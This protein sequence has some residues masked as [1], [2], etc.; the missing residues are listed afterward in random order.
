M[1]IICFLAI[2]FMLV[3]R[4]AAATIVVLAAFVCAGI[5][6]ALINDQPAPATR[7]A[8]MLESGVISSGDPVEVTG[9]VQGEP[10]P[11]PQSFYLTVKAERISVEGIEREASGIV[12]KL[13]IA[14][15][16]A[17]GVAGVRI[18]DRRRCRAP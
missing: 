16:V 15:A 12:F 18:V 3:R 9:V 8:S 1:V 13:R 11:A 17:H 14:A 10:E 2:A 5:S 7:V 6:L 4:L